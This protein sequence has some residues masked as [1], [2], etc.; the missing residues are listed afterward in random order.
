MSKMWLKPGVPCDGQA[1]IASRED[2]SGLTIGSVA[3]REARCLLVADGKPKR[4]FIAQLK[5]LLPL[6]DGVVEDVCAEIRKGKGGEWNG[7]L[8]KGQGK[9]AQKLLELVLQRK[10]TIMKHPLEIDE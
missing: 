7:S 4:G 2:P 10:A 3:K 5:K 6:T 9:P 8:E 1:D